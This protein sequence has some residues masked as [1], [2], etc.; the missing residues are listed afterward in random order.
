MQMTFHVCTKEQKSKCIKRMPRSERHWSSF[1]CVFFPFVSVDLSVSC[2]GMGEVTERFCSVYHHS[3]SR[4]LRI[5]YNI[6]K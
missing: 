6:E 4:I 2:V 1:M 5:I 3:N